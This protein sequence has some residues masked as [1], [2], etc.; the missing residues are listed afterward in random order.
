MKPALHRSLLFWAGIFMMVCISWAWRDSCSYRSGLSWKRYGIESSRSGVAFEH[1]H[2]GYDEWTPTRLYW[3]DALGPTNYFPRPQW[4]TVKT[5]SSEDPK[6]P[7]RE[8]MQVMVNYSGP[9]SWLI[10][11]PY[12]LIL[13]GAA[14]SW[15]ALL[16]WRARRGRQAAAVIEALDPGHGEHGDRA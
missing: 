4:V 5:L 6:D 8:R 9:G 7:L 12:W 10:L 2:D 15:F 1:E 3:P 11:L 13:A 16:L 14:L